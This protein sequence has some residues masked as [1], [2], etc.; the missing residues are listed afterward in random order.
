MLL[1]MDGPADGTSLNALVTMAAVTLFVVMHFP[2][3]VVFGSGLRRAIGE[4][5]AAGRV[6]RLMRNAWHR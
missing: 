2:L 4:A 5:I 1:S 3:S 6:Q